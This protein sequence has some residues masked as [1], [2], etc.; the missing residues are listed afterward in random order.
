MKQTKRI[1]CLLL[2]LLMLLPL[3]VAC[4]KSDDGVNADGAESGDVAGGAGTAAP[5]G[6]GSGETGEQIE[7]DEKGFQKDKLDG[8]NFEGK[9]LRILG[10]SSSIYK[11]LNLAAEDMNKN[12]LSRALYTRDMTV[13][14]RLNVN[15]VYQ[16]ISM[17][18]LA[19]EAA[20]LE[21]QG[22]VDLYAPYSRLSATLMMEGY[23]RNLLDVNYLDFTAPWWTQ[24]LLNKVTIYDKMYV[25]SGDI[26]PSLFA[27]TFMICFNKTLFEEVA[28]DELSQYD[29]ESLYEM[30]EEGTW[31]ID[32]LLEFAKGV[33]LSADDSKDSSDSFGLV[34]DPINVDSFYQ[35]MGLK[36]LEYN[37]D[38]SVKVSED[39]YS[40]KAHGVIEKLNT[41]FD[42]PDGLAPSY[43][44]GP[45][46]ERGAVV[47]TFQNGT[48]LFIV[49][50]V[51]SVPSHLEA[52]V[53]VG[54][55]PM[56]KYNTDQERYNDISGFGYLVWSISRSVTDKL[57]A[58]GAFMEC[59]ASESHRTVAPALFEDVYKG[60]ASSSSDDYKMWET[61]RQSVYVEGGGLFADIFSNKSYSVFRDAV[62]TRT[63]DYMSHS[64]SYRELLEGYADGLNNLMLTLEDLYA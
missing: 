8:L 44:D 18:E 20:A 15:P 37:P 46:G 56:P 64:A 42:T 26:S 25:A 11:E 7:T 17:D 60:Q 49:D 2:A 45:L 27:Q 58:C 59:M 1:L 47:A 63:T 6:D 34:C 39:L 30:V 21:A 61:I 53:D 19:G 13:K 55:L 24:N 31:T 16:Q 10:C 48:A 57:D 50:C 35:A 5:S 22:G 14:A 41:F 28:A 29:A 62:I 40:Q 54:I 38:S 4:K 3:A 9:E 12:E 43:Y 23:T 36:V 33:G 51:V 52:G 32:A